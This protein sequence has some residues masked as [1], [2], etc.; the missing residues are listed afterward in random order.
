MNVDVFLYF[1]FE[2]GGCFF[3]IA[4]MV[5]R[6]FF[7]TPHLGSGIL[8]LIFLAEFFLETISKVSTGS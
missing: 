3:L 8:P 1:F 2:K 5:Y 7:W 4:M 6:R